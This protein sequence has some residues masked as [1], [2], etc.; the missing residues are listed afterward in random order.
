MVRLFNRCLSRRLPQDRDNMDFIC[1]CLSF[2]PLNLRSINWKPCHTMF[3]K[4]FLQVSCLLPVCPL[5]LSY[6]R[7]SIPIP[8][9]YRTWFPLCSSFPSLVFWLRLLSPHDV[10]SWPPLELCLQAPESMACLVLLLF[11]EEVSPIL[12]SSSS[13]VVLP[14]KVLPSSKLS[15]GSLGL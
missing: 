15:S 8:S 4:Y 7:L 9:R 13:A 1:F 3:S 14:N 12:S 5:C 6:F 11:G 2:H 10:P